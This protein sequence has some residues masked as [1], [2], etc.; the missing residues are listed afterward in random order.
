MVLMVH[1]FIPDGYELIVG[2]IMIV[3]ATPLVFY[4]F[5]RFHYITIRNPFKRKK[6]Y[7]KRYGHGL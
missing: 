3:I 1:Q 6:T 4:F 5:N 2:I 7:G